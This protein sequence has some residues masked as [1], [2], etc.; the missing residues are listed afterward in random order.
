MV[1]RRAR[2]P[3]AA[4]IVVALHPDRYPMFDAYYNKLLGAINH[5]IAHHLM[6]CGDVQLDLNLLVSRDTDLGVPATTRHPH[7]VSTRVHQVHP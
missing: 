7:E 5:V 3:A 2:V 1:V 6:L 4:G